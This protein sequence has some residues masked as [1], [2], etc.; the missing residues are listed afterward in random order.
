MTHDACIIPNLLVSELL[1]PC[2]SHSDI[3]GEAQEGPLQLQPTS[4]QGW[5]R[6]A[7]SQCRELSAPVMPSWVMHLDV[8][9]WDGV[10]L[11]VECPSHG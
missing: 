11:G 9:T 5:G 8:M 10:Y 3:K 7:M 4:D 6:G 2:V 1:D